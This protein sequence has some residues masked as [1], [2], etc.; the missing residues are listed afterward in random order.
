ML[1]HA[2][3]RWAERRRREANFKALWQLD[4]HMLNDI[5]VRRGDLLAALRPR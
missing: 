5:G 2:F 4:D 1:K 3:D